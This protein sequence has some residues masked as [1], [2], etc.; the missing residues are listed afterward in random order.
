M[1]R[2]GRGAA[3]TRSRGASSSSRIR[4][5]SMPFTRPACPRRAASQRRR[6][7]SRSC[8]L[9][10]PT[11]PSATLTTMA[12]PR[13]AAPR[14]PSP[15]TCPERRFAR[16]VSSAAMKTILVVDDERHIV[17]LVRLYLEKEGF[18]VVTA[19]DG[20]EALERH[21]RHDP[22]LVVLDVML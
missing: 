12:A 18:A 20:Q 6:P 13:N 2:A 11:A 17:D 4:R 19:N 21:A 5:R 9:R 16:S 14:L 8:C 3:A 10:T 22:D 1:W 15:Y 7:R